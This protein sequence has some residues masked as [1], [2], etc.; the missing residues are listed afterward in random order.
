MQTN[1]C[2]ID[3]KV[4][5]HWPIQRFAGEAI[6]AAVQPRFVVA[7][8]IANTKAPFACSQVTLNAHSVAFFA[9]DSITKVFEESEVLGKSYRMTIEQSDIDG[10]KAYTIRVAA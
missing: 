10:K 4:L 2:T 9:I 3:V 1:T 7:L 8:L 6:L 5:V